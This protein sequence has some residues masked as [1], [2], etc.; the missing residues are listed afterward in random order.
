MTGNVVCDTDYEKLIIY[1]GDIDPKK[2][3]KLMKMFARLK[4]PVCYEQY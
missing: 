1:P 4:V 2:M 3:N